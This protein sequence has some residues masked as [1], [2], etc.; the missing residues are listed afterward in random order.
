MP[1]AILGLGCVMGLTLKCQQDPGYTTRRF[2]QQTEQEAI[3]RGYNHS[4]PQ[5]MWS[6]EDILLSDKSKIFCREVRETETDLICEV[7]P[8]HSWSCS[9]ALAV[10]T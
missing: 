4:H 7:K 9:A 2:S 10:L 5:R 6:I 3:Q 8:F 1:P